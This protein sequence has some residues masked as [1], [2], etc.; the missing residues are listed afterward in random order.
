MDVVNTAA[1]EP[2]WLIDLNHNTRKE[3]KLPQKHRR[4]TEKA[5]RHS[6]YVLPKDSVTITK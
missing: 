6:K 5:D 1:T 4:P 2:Y 3:Y